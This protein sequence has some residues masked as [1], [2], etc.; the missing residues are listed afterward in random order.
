MKPERWPAGAPQRLV[1]DDSTGA[2]YPMYG[3]DEEGVH[4][5]GWAFTDIDAA[6]TKSFIVEHHDDEEYEKYFPVL[7]GKRSSILVE[8]AD[9]D[10]SFTILSLDAKKIKKLAELGQNPNFNTNI[11]LALILNQY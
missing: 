2:L 11:R 5:S 6:P 9:G 1:P 4:H 8:L 7:F 3:I 10:D